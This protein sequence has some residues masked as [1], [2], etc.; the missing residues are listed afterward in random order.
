MIDFYQP[1]KQP[2]LPTNLSTG[3]M[4]TLWNKKVAYFHQHPIS[5]ALVA[6]TRVLQIYGSRVQYVYIEISQ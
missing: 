5:I 3:Y 4:L 1:A 2:A 6:D